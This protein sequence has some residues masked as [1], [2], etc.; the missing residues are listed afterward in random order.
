[1]TGVTWHCN[2]VALCI[3]P[4][5]Q[6][7]EQ[8]HPHKDPL[9]SFITT[10]PSFLPP[11]FLTPVCVTQSC[12]TLCDPMGCSPPGSSIHGILQARRLEWGAIPFSSRS[13]WPRDWT[14]ISCIAGRSFTIWATWEP[15][16][17][18]LATLNLFSV[19]I[20]LSFQECYINE[21]V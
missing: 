11:L 5:S 16:S 19:S 8:V 4:Y 10:P 12:P 13:S 17:L 15:L 1:M 3:Q 14:R 2:T 20:I 6:D 7:T 18:P 9:W 21:I